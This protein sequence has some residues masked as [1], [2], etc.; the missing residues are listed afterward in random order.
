[1]LL[2]SGSNSADLCS[3]LFLAASACCSAVTLASMA[4]LKFLENSKLTMLN[5]STKMFLS[6][7]P[8]FQLSL[9]LIAHQ[10]PLG[11]QFFCSEL[12]RRSFDGLLHSRIND[13]IF[14]LQADV[15]VH[16]GNPVRIDVKVECHDGMHC[17]QILRCG[18]GLHFVFLDLDIHHLNRLDE[19]KSKIQSFAKHLSGDGGESQVHA[20]LPSRNRAEWRKEGKEKQGNDPYGYSNYIF[21]C[22][23]MPH[24][25]GGLEVVCFGHKS[26]PLESRF[27]LLPDAIRSRFQI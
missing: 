26:P 1:M 13:S 21:S 3:S 27:K 4:S 25:I 19:W 22:Q 6:L 11:D 9:D 16:I 18:V 14:E 12:R 2:S 20:A 8:G 10:F 15:L 23:A 24:E 17:L 7:K 5:S